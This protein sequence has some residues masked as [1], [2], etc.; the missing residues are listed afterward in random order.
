MVALLVESIE[1][2]GDSGDESIEDI[3]SGLSLSKFDDNESLSHV[4]VGG[5]FGIIVSGSSWVLGK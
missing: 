1:Q 5:V 4:E 3:D 2:D